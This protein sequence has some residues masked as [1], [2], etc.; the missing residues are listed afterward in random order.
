MS[1]QI[2]VINNS[3]N[4]ENSS[5]TTL[6]FSNYYWGMGNYLVSVFIYILIRT[7]HQRFNCVVPPPLSYGI[8]NFSSTLIYI[9]VYMFSMH[10]YRIPVN[11]SPIKFRSKKHKA[12][13]YSHVSKLHIL[14]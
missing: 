7:F 10:N 6:Y 1:N 14:V 5:R 11:F 9:I 12:L 13:I 4:S 8:F 3:N 2:T